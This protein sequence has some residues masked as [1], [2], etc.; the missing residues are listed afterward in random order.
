MNVRSKEHDSTVKNVEHLGAPFGLILNE[1][2]EHWSLFPSTEALGA[3]VL[4][5][6]RKTCITTSHESRAGN[7][8]I[9]SPES[10]E[11]IS[12]SVEL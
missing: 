5:G 3:F 6:E 11:I 1:L 7:P 8:S 4:F 2:C 12:D 9:R 10:S